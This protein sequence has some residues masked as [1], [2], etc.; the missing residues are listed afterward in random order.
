AGRRLHLDR[1]R[2]AW[3][4]GADTQGGRIRLA[5]RQAAPPSRQMD[6]LESVGEGVELAAHA[7]LRPSADA[8]AACRARGAQRSGARRPAL[9]SPGNV[10]DPPR[11][12]ER[13]DFPTA[14]WG[15]N[16]DV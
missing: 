15:A 10:L 11:E 9:D 2:A 12:C 13:S 5:G 8:L 1:R 7:A 6:L 14:R 4:D 3:P 16:L